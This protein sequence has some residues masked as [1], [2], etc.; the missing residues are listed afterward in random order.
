MITMATRTTTQD[1][2]AVTL[3][4]IVGKKRAEEA[5]G[6]LI[7]CGAALDAAQTHR[8]GVDGV[9]RLTVPHLADWAA[10]DFRPAPGLAAGALRT[11]RRVLDADPGQLEELTSALGARL[12]AWGSRAGAAPLLLF[13]SAAELRTVAARPGEPWPAAKAPE[14]ARLAAA[15]GV[16]S[17]LILPLRDFGTLTLVR[18]ADRADGPFGAGAVE[19]AIDVARRLSSVSAAFLAQAADVST[20]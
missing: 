6:F 15:A 14:L 12:P 18:M 8:D 20:G 4:Y 17:A 9:L 1:S 13:A 3:D 19:L 5:L 7:A 11:A 2:W 16:E 10:A